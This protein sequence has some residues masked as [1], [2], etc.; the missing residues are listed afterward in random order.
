M[1]RDRCPACL[2]ISRTSCVNEPRRFR[3]ATARS[4][5]S[6]AHRN[7]CEPVSWSGR[8][9]RQPFGQLRPRGYGHSRFCELYEEWESRLS[10][11]MRQV[12]PAGAW[13]FVDN[14]GQTVDFPIEQREVD[15]V[16][17]LAV[18]AI[19]RGQAVAAIV[20]SS[21][22]DPKA[23]RIPFA[24][25]VSTS[26]ITGSTFTAIG[27]PHWFALVVV[28]LLATSPWLSYRFSLRTLLIAT[29]LVA[30][31]LGLIVWSAR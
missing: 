14:A 2:C 15:R 26:G 29:T 13:L 28:A 20:D 21:P 6:C 5:I 16:V 11:T 3:C 27:L 7:L 10:P 18:A 9:V 22:L 8:L 23:K 31:V 17:H 4:L 24:F 25:K 12:H 19:A 30:V 1:M